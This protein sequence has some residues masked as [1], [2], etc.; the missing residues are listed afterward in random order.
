MKKETVY[1]LKRRLSAV[2]VLILFYLNLPNCFN[3]IAMANGCKGL[4][5]ILGI[6][7]ND[8]CF[9]CSGD[10]TTVYTC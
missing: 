1:F 10:Y 9:D 8:Q 3:N 4:E 5:G 2:N 7:G 6:D